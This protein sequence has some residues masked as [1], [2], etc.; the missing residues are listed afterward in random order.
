[1]SNVSF[2]KL[3]EETLKKWDEQDIFKKSISS[4]EGKKEFTFYDGPPFATGLP[5]YGHLLAGTIKDIVP[6]YWTMKGCKVDRVFGWDCHGLPV[7]NEVENILNLSGKRAI[8]ELG[9]EKFN[10]KCR[11]IVLRYTGE[12]EKTVKRIGRWV[13]FKNGYKTMDTNF[14]ESIWWV[15]KQLW[16]KNLIYQGTKVVPFSWAL[17]TALSNFEAN[18]NYQEVQDPA[19]T[20][21][22]KLSD[23]DAYIAAWTTTPWTLPSNLAL[24]VGREIDYVKAY[25]EAEKKYIIM[26]EKRLDAYTKKHGLVVKERF[27]GSDLVGKR[28]EP[29]FPYFSHLK[30]DG[31]FQI[32][33]DGY[34]STENGTGVV[35]TAPSFG[36][37]DNRVVKQSGLHLDACPVD[38]NGCFTKEVSDYVGVMVKDAD[39]LIIR[40]LKDEGKLYEMSQIVHSYPFCYRTDTPLLYKSI[41]SWYVKVE[42]IK[43]KMVKAN[44]NI[45]WVPDHLKEGRFGNWLEGAR[46]WAISRNRSW[47]TPLPIWVNDETKKCICIG[48][49]DELEKYTGVRVNDLHRET[50]DHL[51]FKVAGESGTYVR[52]KDVLDC[53]FESGSMPYAQKHYP[54]EN[55]KWFEENFPADFI[56]EGIDQTRGWFYTLVVLASALFDKN[57]FKNVIVNGLI[58]AEDG[59]KMSKRKK[60]YPPADEVIN[61]Y[62][63]DPLRLFLINSPVVVAKD[64]KF[65]EKGIEEIIRAVILPLWSSYSFLTTYAEVD[66]WGPEKGVLKSENQLD[67]W[68]LSKLQSLIEQVDEEMQ[69]YNL[70]KVVPV[71][72]EFVEYLTNWYIRLSRRR[73]WKSENDTD[74]DSAY[75][76]LYQVLTSFSKVMAP[77]LPFLTDYIYTALT[78]DD[79]NEPFE[80]VHLCDF[81]LPNK[82]L[83]DKN[84]EDK[85]DMVRKAVELG[86][87]L[88]SKHNLKTRQPLKSASVVVNDALKMSYFQELSGLIKNELNVKNVIVSSNEDQLVS[89]S[90]KPNLKLLGP[91]FGKQMKE[92]T[93]IIK[94]LDSSVIAQLEAGGK[95]DVLGKELS[96]EHF[97]IDR[98]PKS[99][100]VVESDLGITVALDT[101]VSPELAQECLAREMVNRIQNLRKSADFEV[102]DTITVSVLGDPQVNESLQ[103]FGEYLKAETLTSELLT[104]NELKAPDISESF[105]IDGVKVSISVKR[106]K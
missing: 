51:T 28:Y 60:N 19:I 70:N 106:N 88:R 36:E 4:R 53:W 82:E 66:G 91:L 87:S 61:K 89:K 22:F 30:A 7:E 69:N 54:F 35:H 44:Q 31:A 13:D 45:R 49:L 92:A 104:T 5:H 41:S 75:S 20:I 33:E 21:L 12:W 79:K 63:A 47:G 39:K 103:T 67:R 85:M 101:E 27:K 16:D 34:V 23:E 29:L 97:L 105:D 32:L 99:G 64:L 24:C 100:Y 74:K 8:E 50:I 80:S 14:M 46:D 77:F 26:A 59:S 93:E 38:E 18:Q 48:S 3:E 56:A 1:M 81:P 55:V 17:G 25:D 11:E 94:G 96:I 42:D 6:R 9:V 72:V 86:R 52:I 83:Q 76:T 2:P 57:P 78:A 84:L 98:T 58:L 40:R 71:L 95:F 73:F 43:D 102:S 90:T 65:S 68:I 37:D 15:F 62:G 10:A